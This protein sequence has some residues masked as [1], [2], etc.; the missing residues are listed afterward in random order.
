MS[1]NGNKDA[2]TSFAF[3]RRGDLPGSS[4]FYRDSSEARDAFETARAAQIPPAQQPAR[5]DREAGGVAARRPRVSRF[6]L[7]APRPSFAEPNRK[8]FEEDWFQKL[9]QGPNGA[10]LTKQAFLEMREASKSGK[11]H[12]H[13]YLHNSRNKIL[14]K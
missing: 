5:A 14:D 8:R 6:D 13:K 1:K 12:T 11:P 7:P 10:P 4:S 9:E 3:Q 2:R